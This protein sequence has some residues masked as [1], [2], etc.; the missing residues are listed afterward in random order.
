[1]KKTASV[2][3]SGQL[4]VGCNYWASHAGTAMWSDWQPREVQK[5]LAS[6]ARQGLQVLRVFPMWPDFQP[7]TLL[8]TARATPVEFRF[9]EEPLPDDEWGR[10]GVSRSAM[11]HFRFLADC[12]AEQDLHLV[13]GLITGWMS[14][15]LFVPPAFDGLDP[16][17]NPMV[18][19]W[20]LRFVREFVKEFKDHPAILAWDLG[21]EC[22]CMGHATAEQSWVWT[23]GVVSTIRSIDPTR[24]VISGM[25]SLS[26]DPWAAWNLEDQGELTD[27]LTTHPYPPFTPHCDVDP[28][29]TV[30]SILHATAESTLYSDIGGKP[31]LVEE[32]G[33]LGPMFADRQVAASFSRSGLWSA[34]AHD[35]RA[36]IWW[37]AYDQSHLDAAPYDWFTVERELGLCTA[38]REP[39][40]VIHEF[41]SFRRFLEKLSMGPLPP[42]RREAVCVLTR[43]QDQ[44]G[45]AYMTFVL[46]KLAGFELTFVAP[47]QPAPDAEL[48]LVPSLRGHRPIPRRRFQAILDRVRAGATLYLSLDDGLPDGLE[49]LAGVEVIHRS[50]R[51]GALNL[52]GEDLPEIPLSTPFRL[53]LRATRA[54]VLAAESDGNPLFTRAALGRGWVYF[55]AGS[56][57]KALLGRPGAFAP[58]AAPVWNLYRQVAKKALHGRVIQSRT[59]AQLGVT[60]HPVDSRHR[61]AVAINYQPDGCDV[62]LGLAKGWNIRR[63]IRNR[64]GK[65]EIKSVNPAG[66]WTGHV[67]GNDGLILELTKDRRA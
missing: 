36:F 22:N 53:T 5:D 30:R 39:K 55:L 2:F 4:S 63:V 51:E 64:G 11:E 16:I 31:C 17:T 43:D 15:R 27:F 50:R 48:Y 32:V 6:L 41:Q 18:V 13:I 47:H 57:E 3:A 40:P 14:G 42:R 7:L 56:P 54:E 24:P 19:Q 66:T 29:N 21:N 38:R 28:V 37:C 10:A 1:M 23:A 61:I 49:A 59:A 25:H 62:E 67:P 20:Q 65:P 44:W 33:T 12:A 45:T 60:E 34:W 35:H 26:A 8:R 9:G 58:E 52:T 46:A